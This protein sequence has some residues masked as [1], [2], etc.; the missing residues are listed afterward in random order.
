M[1]PFVSHAAC[2][3]GDCMPENALAPSE[4]NIGCITIT[5]VIVTRPTRHDCSAFSSHGAAHTLMALLVHKPQ[6]L[7]ASVCIEIQDI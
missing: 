1:R 3:R 2:R 7:A 6:H 5:R 4:Y